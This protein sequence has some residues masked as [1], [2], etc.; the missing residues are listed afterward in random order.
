MLSKAGS[1]SARQEIF[2]KSTLFFLVSQIIP[3][4]TLAPSFFK[5]NIYVFHSGLPNG[6]FLQV[7]PPKPSCISHV[8]HTCHMFFLFILSQ[9]ITVMRLVWGANE[10]AVTYA[11]FSRLLLL[12]LYRNEYNTYLNTVFPNILSCI[13]P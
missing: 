3:S 10:A 11:T 4:Y 8:P 12:F 13:L 5:I 2:C 1:S 9:F 6:L 7:F